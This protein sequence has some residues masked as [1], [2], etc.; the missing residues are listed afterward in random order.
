MTNVLTRTL[1]VDAHEMAPLHVWGELFG[2]AAARVADLFT[3]YFSSS[4][5]NDFYNPN[6][7]GDIAAV[8]DESVWEIRGTTAPSSFDLT[9]RVAV[10][11]QMGIDR[12][13]I[14]PSFA[15]L[16]INLIGEGESFLRRAAGIDLPHNELESIGRA[17][18]AEYNDWV[19]RVTAIDPAR[20]RPVAYLAPAASVRELVEQTEELLSRGIR[21]VHINAGTPPAG[22]SPAHTE[23]DAFWSLLADNDV[24][25]TTHLGSEHGFLGSGEWAR[26]EAFAPGNV[27]GHEIG[28]EP[29]SFATLHFAAMNFLVC[30]VLGGVFERQPRLRFGVIEVGAAWLGPLADHLDMWAEGVHAVRLSKVLS[31]KPSAYLARNVRVTPFNTVERVD[32]Y[33]ARYPHLQDCYCYSTDYPHTEGGKRSK[34]KLAEQLSAVDPT[35]REKFFA[36][37]A[38]LLLPD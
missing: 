37:N 5:H 23:L 30:M 17:G 19:V 2:P 33:L 38:A 3:P 21:A 20:L 6:H 9:R 31:M 10:M 12:Q 8:T 28:I 15:I 27:P 22:R 4:G 34:E 13:L 32:E 24:A 7:P 18:L 25:C 1:D 26:A 11:T 16:A 29:Y 36:V 14:F 35:L